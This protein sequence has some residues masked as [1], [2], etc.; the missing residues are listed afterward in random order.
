MKV[1]SNIQAMIAGKVLRGNESRLS[2]STEK[3]SSGYRINSGKD[4]PA[5]LAISNKMRAQIQ[6]LNKANQNAS[7]AVNVIETAE[8]ALAEIQ[9]MVQRISEL[10]VKAANGTNTTEDRNAIQEE[11]KQLTKEITRVAQDTEYNT[12][13]LL[14][15]EQSLKGYTTLKGF[16]V[17]QYDPEFPVG[18]DY[19]ISFAKDKDGKLTSVSLDNGFETTA[20]AELEGNKIKIT[21]KDGAEMV[22]QVNSIVGEGSYSSVG[23]E[24][25]GIGGMKI[26]VGAKEGQEIVVAI[27][28]VSLDNM[29]LTGID[30]TTEDGAKTALDQAADALSFISAVRSRLGAY[31]NRFENTISNLDVS[32]E[33]LTQS[34]STIK[35]VDMA[36]EMVE[37]TTLQ[38]LVQ[39]GTSMLSQ[40]NEQPQQA[41]QLLQ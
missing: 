3:L 31:E 28:A 36:E 16:N 33:N 25:N 35:D 21:N 9:D 34:Y 30:V 6:S 14:G 7:N 39:A 17:L 26:Q 2:S 29:N 38:V 10:S 20:K 22:L 5:G 15:G 41:L 27:P 19:E 32:T 11:I 4:N 23:V 24:V 1:N 13:N 40:A 18:K 37:Y 8:G 12:Q